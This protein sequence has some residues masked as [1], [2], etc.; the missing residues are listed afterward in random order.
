MWLKTI[1]V[2]LNKMQLVQH[3]QRRM[4]VYLKSLE[5]CQFRDALTLQRRWLVG[6]V[7]E[8]CM[9]SGALY[10]PT[11]NRKHYVSMVPFSTPPLGAW[12]LTSD[13]GSTFGIMLHFLVY[14]FRMLSTMRP[15]GVVNRVRAWQ[16]GNTH[17]CMQRVTSVTCE[18]GASRRTCMLTLTD[19]TFLVEMGI[20][21]NPNRTRTLILEEPN[22]TRTHQTKKYVEPEPNRTHEQEEPEPI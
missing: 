7:R 17:R 21:P 19:L 4:F 6:R 16:V 12:L 13:L 10:G 20:E 11:V 15:S 22:R 3:R 5:M 8:V 14:D 9:L 1:L 2:Q 18:W